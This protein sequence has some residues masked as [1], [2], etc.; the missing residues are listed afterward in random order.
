MTLPEPAV[1]DLLKKK[2]VVG[3]VNNQKKKYVGVSGGY[4]RRQ[5]AV[6]TTNGAGARNVQIFMLSKDLRVLH[7]LPGFWHPVDFERALRFGLA[8]DRLWRDDSRT[9]MQRKNMFYRMQRAEQRMRPMAMRARSQWQRFDE[10]HERNRNRQKP[11]D[12]LVVM[13]PNGGWARIKTIDEIVHDRM[14]FYPF[15]PFAKFDTA[16]FADLGRPR[17]DL[18]RKVDRGSTGFWYAER[19]NRIRRKAEAKERAAAIKVRKRQLLKKATRD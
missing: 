15:V 3:W 10:S 7:A 16:S 14:V 17:Y 11:R 13:N 5:H 9:E 18:N 1:L 12:T 8:L 2:F 19:N 4:H 6:G